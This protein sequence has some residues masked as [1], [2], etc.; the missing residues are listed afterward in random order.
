MSNYWFA[1][2][3]QSRICV[4]WL[5][6]CKTARVQMGN[7]LTTLIITVGPM[8]MFVVYS[9]TIFLTR[10]TPDELNSRAPPIDIRTHVPYVC[11]A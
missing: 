1:P 9:A 8:I 6:I 7:L 3:D 10:K 5:I 4:L 2:K 11:V